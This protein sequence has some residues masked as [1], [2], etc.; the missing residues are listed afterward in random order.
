MRAVIDS[1][2]RYISPK[3]VCLLDYV[4]RFCCHYTPLLLTI[5][6]LVTGTIDNFGRPIN[7]MVPAEFSGFIYIRCKGAWSSFVHQYCHVTG[8]YMKIPL[9]ASPTLLDFTDGNE[10]PTDYFNEFKSE[11]RVYVNYYQWVPFLLIGLAVGM[12]LPHF[13]LRLGHSS[14]VLHVDF[15]VV[16]ELCEKVKSESAEM[17]LKNVDMAA[18]YIFQ[19]VKHRGMRGIGSKTILFYTLFKFAN[20]L[21][22]IG[23]IFLLNFF[24][25]YGNPFWGVTVIRQIFTPIDST[26]PSKSYFSYFP[27]VAYCEFNRDF[28]GSFQGGIIQEARCTLGINMLNEKV[29]LILFFWYYTLLA[30]SIFAFVYY[31]RLWFGHAY[32]SHFIQDFLSLVNDREVFGEDATRTT[33]DSRNIKRFGKCILGSDG[34]LLFHFLRKNLG[35]L[36]CVEVCSRLYQLFQN[37]VV[38]QQRNTDINTF[39]FNQIIILMRM[40]FS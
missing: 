31:T 17:R 33:L 7:C 5:F 11:R 13:L 8:T 19:I 2:A 39:Y 30:M 37:D 6:M 24:I 28:L 4:D 10:M 27:R 16:H 25:G 18:N 32:Q 12:R 20:L 15:S 40:T 14:S 9:E 35:G 36:V 1:V 34:I 22:I 3:K 23:Q 38:Q 21:M 29:F 26:D